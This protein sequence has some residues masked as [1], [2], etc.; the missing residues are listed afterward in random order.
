[1]CVCLYFSHSA[2]NPHGLL[3]FVVFRK[4]T[5]WSKEYQTKRIEYHE[6]NERN[7]RD[8]IVEHAEIEN[9]VCMWKSAHETKK[10]RKWAKERKR[11]NKRDW[12]LFA[13]ILFWWMVDWWR[14]NVASTLNDWKF[15]LALAHYLHK[16]TVII[17]INSIQILGHK[18][19]LLSYFI[20]V[21]FNLN[22]SGK[23]IYSIRRFVCA[24]WCCMLCVCVWARGQESTYWTHQALD[25]SEKRKKC[26]A[27]TH[28]AN[29]KIR[30]GGVWRIYSHK[31][32]L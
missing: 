21:P 15:I 1:M 18:T 13:F 2:S 10:Q 6:L 31:C 4:K 23:T 9:Y 3:A 32:E 24:V 8:Y 29:D 12:L 20:V 5:I 19:L 30:I 16:N 25:L 22:F 14:S 28:F 26:C 27:W 11:M 17:V 7:R